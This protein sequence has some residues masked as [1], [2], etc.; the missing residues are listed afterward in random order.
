MNKPDVRI[1][2]SKL[3]KSFAKHPVLQD[4]DWCIPSG[5]VVGL[6]GTNGSGKTTLIQCLLGLLK[7][8]S[9]RVTIDDEDAW[10][11]SANTKARIGYVDQR[12]QFYPWMNG[13]DLLKYVGAMYPHWNDALCAELAKQWIVPLS[14]PFGKLSPGE[15]QKV[16]ILTALG[17]EP[18][19]LIL[20]EPVSSLDPLARRAFLKSLLEIARNESRTIVFSTHITSDVERVASHVAFLHEGKIQWFDELDVTKERIR[21]LRFRSNQDFPTTLSIPGALHVQVDGSMAVAAVAG[22][23]KAD[24][25][26]VCARYDASVEVE[27]LNLEEIFLELHHVDA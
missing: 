25:D 23:E 3:C 26:A 4:V 15:Q 27:E 6:L 24:I 1:E 9:G 2:I 5:T 16:A 18:D 17:N 13:A 11:L 20:D 14:K 19:L 12:P 21:R 7:A 10:D 8:D 22:T